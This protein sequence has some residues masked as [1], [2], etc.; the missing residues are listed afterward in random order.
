[1]KKEKNT[2]SITP[3]VN[4]GEFMWPTAH[5]RWSKEGKL[6]QRW[7]GMNGEQ[8]WMVIAVEEETE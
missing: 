1:M 4:F 8:V 3:D 7:D 5:L 6:Q 2:T